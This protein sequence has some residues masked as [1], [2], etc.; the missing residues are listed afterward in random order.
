MLDP[1][2]SVETLHLE[3]L[4]EFDE[5]IGETGFLAATDEPSFADI[6]AFA[7]VAFLTTY[8]FETNLTT[9]SSP[10]VSAWYDRIKTYL[11]DNP[12]PA[13]FPQ[14]PPAGFQATA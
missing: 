1:E 14:W 10:T 3:V 7:E 13:L 4:Q 8:G 12:A 6:A 11:P 2:K 5:H 9:A